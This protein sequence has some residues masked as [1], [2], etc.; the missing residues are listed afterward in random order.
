MHVQFELEAG[1][2]EALKSLEDGR[3]KIELVATREAGDKVLATVYVP[4]GELKVFEHKIQKYAST[5]TPKGRPAHETLIAPIT[6]I[7]LA[8][9]RD[10]WT[11]DDAAFPATNAVARWEIWITDYRRSVTGESGSNNTSGRPSTR[12]ST[13]RCPGV[14]A[15]ALSVKGMLSVSLPIRSTR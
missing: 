1:H 6:A 12:W 7:R 9:L 13:I 10:F 5:N 15:R 11:D 2:V 8:A 14:S 3:K 4:K